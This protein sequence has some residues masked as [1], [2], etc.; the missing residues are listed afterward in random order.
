MSLEVDSNRLYRMIEV[1]LCKSIVYE[2][3]KLLPLKRKLR[4]DLHHGNQLSPDMLYTSTA[5]VIVPDG[6]REESS[7]ALGS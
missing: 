7:F 5:A 1:S 2:R 4:S 6:G 3:Y